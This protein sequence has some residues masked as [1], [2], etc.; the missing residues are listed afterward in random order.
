MPIYLCESKQ[1]FCRIFI[2][3]P[4]FTRDEIERHCRP[5]SIH[6]VVL[7]GQFT[8]LRDVT[9]FYCVAF[10]SEKQMGVTFDDNLFDTA[11]D[12]ERYARELLTMLDLAR[13]TVR[14]SIIYLEDEEH[15][16]SSDGPVIHVTRT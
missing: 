6:A 11:E 14:R 4:V 13:V 10:A 15:S 8:L 3:N 16:Y 1:G 9:Y 5:G 7:N 12:A 2:P